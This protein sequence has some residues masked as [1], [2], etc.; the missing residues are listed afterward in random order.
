MNRVNQ[1]NDEVSE[2]ARLMVKV[3]RLEAN[4]ARLQRERDLA[5]AGR[6]DHDLMLQTLPYG[7]A[8]IDRH[9][10]ISFVNDTACRLLQRERSQLLG[11][12]LQ[13]LNEL[14]PQL[15]KIT[16][17]LQPTPELHEILF[18]QQLGE[19]NREIR[20]TGSQ[21]FAANGERVE[22][23]L[24]FEDVTLQRQREQMKTDAI[25]MA[26]HEL[27]SPLTTITGFTEYLMV[28][29]ELPEPQR[30]EYFGYV[31]EKAELMTNLI[32][33]MQEISRLEKGQPLLLCVQSCDLR[34]LVQQATRETGWHTG[35]EAIRLQLPPAPVKLLLD[36]N[37][38]N[39]LIINLI[40]NAV[41]YSPEGSPITIRMRSYANQV[42]VEIIDQGSGIP[43]DQLGKVFQ[44]YYRVPEHRNQARGLGLGLTICQAIVS[45]HGGSIKLTSD[46]GEG[47]TASFTLPLLNE[48]LQPPRQGNPPGTTVPH[49]NA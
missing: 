25:S 39:Q 47:T 6:R 8:V 18:S 35:T 16:E 32:A 9:D 30:R 5:L 28:N 23:L 37:R 40:S 27:R 12:P 41:K 2:L 11:Q 48:L 15:A 17:L 24:Q 36:R 14:H 1:R 29:P 3:A 46:Y 31:L 21:V 20:V 43:A 10:T 33:D 19:A 42:V 22:S 13:Q 7:L 45:A 34:E 49:P 38:I 26:G 4:N 44:H